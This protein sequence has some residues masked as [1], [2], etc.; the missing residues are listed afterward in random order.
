[1]SEQSYY[2]EK[3]IKNASIGN[4]DVN[5]RSRMTVKEESISY[6]LSEENLLK[7]SYKAETVK[8]INNNSNMKSIKDSDFLEFYQKMNQKLIENE[9]GDY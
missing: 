6:N 7:T 5:S 1:M 9:T 4:S 3:S 8:S 2:K